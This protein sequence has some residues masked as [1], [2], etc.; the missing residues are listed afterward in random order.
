MKSRFV[1]RIGLAVAAVSLLMAGL[2]TQMA[3]AATPGFKQSKAVEVNTG[4]TANVALTSAAT[5]GDLIVVQVLWSNTGSVTITDSRGD[6]FAAATTRTTWGTT[7]GAQTFYAKNVVGGTTTVTATFGTALSDFAIVQAH[8]YTGVDKTNP[9]DGAVGAAGTTATASSGNLTVAGSNDL[10]VAGGGAYGTLGAAP[11]G[12]TAR[13]NTSGNR[14][15]D[16][17]ATSAGTYSFS[18]SA[19][20]NRWVMQMVAFKA[21][22]GTTADTTAPTAPATLTAAAASPTQAN[23]SWPTATDN[24]GVTGYQVERCQGAGCSSFTQVGTTTGATTYSDTGLSASTSYSYRVR[25]TDAAGNL[26]AYSPTATATTPAASDTTAPSVPTGLNGTGTSLSQTSLNW[27]ASTDNVGVTGYK[28]YRNG[29]QVGTTATASYA[30]SGLAAGA[31]YNYTVSAYD[32]AGNNSAQTSAVAVS[33]LA[34]TTAPSVPTNLSATA[35]S[36]T[37]VNLSWTASTDNVGVTGYKIYRGGS[38]LATPA[39]TSYQNTGLTAGTSYSYTVSAVDAAGNESAQS[40]A[41]QA[42]TTAPDTTGPTVSVSAPTNG[43]T[44]SGTIAFSANAS[45]SGSGVHD[46]QFYVDG[47]AVNDDTSSPY[48]YQWNTTS[49]ANGSHQLSAVATDNAGNMTVSAAVTVTVNN[50][51][52]GG[53]P[54]P[55]KIMPLGDSLTQGGVG[56]TSG[57]NPATINGYRL[58]LWNLLSDYT[59]NY[60]GPYQLGD[61]SLSDQD[62]AGESGACIMVSPCGG[63][64]M[65]PLTAGWLNTYNPDLV[66]MQGGGNDYSKS[67]VTDQNVESY[68]EQWIQLV[69]QTKPNVK[70]I[71]SGQAQWH[72]E[73]EAM[74]KAYVEG[75]QAQGKP[76]RF[77]PFAET[78]GTDA[79][80]TDLTHPNA[81]GYQIWANELAPK[82]R[83]LFPQ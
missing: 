31:S 75:L 27:T 24:I 53:V 65:Y 54:N 37:Q 35:V 78:V 77:V 4:T 29:T 55:L 51:T 22:T 2:L 83:E 6:S 33:T 32:A 60:V 36:S 49:V 43:A 81:N 12:W 62:L 41:A 64:T 74:N 44:V 17:V 42:T 19:T 21:D 50:T 79:N 28:V 39:A 61:S 80:T 46:V 59:I 25:A 16:K 48:S 38:L 11:T 56:G 63:H 20:G 8:E 66:I 18:T 34:D 5:A 1:R 52:G 72:P 23:L 57:L 40:T 13:L 71:V 82:V 10:L 30:D 26:G 68:L 73:L 69:W 58:N 3:S 15:Y 47:T 70:I 14:T 45:D 76:I 7:W 9:L 67:G